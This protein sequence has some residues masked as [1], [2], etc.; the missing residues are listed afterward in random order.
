L[1]IAG[2][3]FGDKMPAVVGCTGAR[4]EPEHRRED[5]RGH[6][7][8]RTRDEGSRAARAERAARENDAK[9]IVDDVKT[10]VG[11]EFQA[12]LAALA[13]RLKAMPGKLPI[14]KIWCAESITYEGEFVS[15]DGALWQAREDTAKAPGGD[16]WLCVAR[17]GMRSR[18]M[19]ATRITHTWI[20]RPRVMRSTAT[21]PH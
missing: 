20:E 17:G 19:F 14:A 4:D 16:A 15:H 13:E 12:E 1:I 9:A 18:H 6:H 21:A 8:L 10:F 3:V 11:S 2:W 5:P 7:P